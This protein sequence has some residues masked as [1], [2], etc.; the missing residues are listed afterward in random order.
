LKAKKKNPDLFMEL[1]FDVI[2]HGSILQEQ[3]IPT[4]D[5]KE[6][7]SVAGI[8]PCPV[9]IPLLDRFEQLRNSTE[10]R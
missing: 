6:A 2:D 7:L 5:S 10:F 1:L 9:R 8:L 3:G 4:S